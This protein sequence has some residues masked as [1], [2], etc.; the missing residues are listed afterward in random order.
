[1][2]IRDRPN[3]PFEQACERLDDFRKVVENESIELPKGTTHVTCS[4]GMSG[5]VTQ[6]ID[7][8]ISDADKQLYA[9]KNSGRNKVMFDESLHTIYQ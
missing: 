7:K 9:A 4:I 1:M 6:R 8:L 3:T 2:C 5:A